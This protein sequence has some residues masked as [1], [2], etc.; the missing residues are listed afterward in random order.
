MT[1]KLLIESIDNLIKSLNKEIESFNKLNNKENPNNN[2][3][4]TNII[5]NYIS[6]IK[7]FINKKWWIN[8]I[9]MNYKD[10]IDWKEFS[11]HN[12]E[13]CI[14]WL[15]T[16]N[17]LKKR[18]NR[19]YFT[20]SVP[21][22]N[23]IFNN[24]LNIEW[25]FPELESKIL[26][27]ENPL[28]LKYNNILKDDNL[29]NLEKKF[30]FITEYLNEVSHTVDAAWIWWMSWAT[31]F[32][33]LYSS[34]MNEKIINKDNRND[35]IKQ[36]FEV[37][38]YDE[39]KNKDVNDFIKNYDKFIELLKPKNANNDKRLSRLYNRLYFIFSFVLNN[40]KPEEFPI[41]FSATRNTLRF[42]WIEW[43]KN[44][45]ETYKKVLELKIKIEKQEEEIYKE[46]LECVWIDE[47]KY[48]TELKEKFLFN[49]IFFENHAKYRFFQDLCWV[50]NRNVLNGQDFINNLW[51]WKIF[52]F[53]ILKNKIYTFENKD[54]SV[55]EKIKKLEENWDDE[56]NKKITFWE[57]ININYLTSEWYIKE[58]SPWEYEVL[59][60][61]DYYIWKK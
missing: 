35:I 34:I 55:L 40:Q 12:R 11:S 47:K 43:Y 10:S 56:E 22:A 52:N 5:N 1:N 26:S 51:K 48:C 29:N 49:K 46:Y 23:Y 16:K 21:Y 25:D 41:Y 6:F 42:F 13:Q 61:D 59:K 8:N 32:I 53:E 19:R 9:L 4:E 30:K 24:F 54:F 7:E 2:I 58:I 20:W 57:I 38:K 45:T 36:L 3:S 15:E 44:I 50:L 27:E 14:L 39:D 17:E 31:D 37:L 60:I 33:Q 18:D 28:I